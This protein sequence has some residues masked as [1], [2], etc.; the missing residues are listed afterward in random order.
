[1][2]R[3]RF[4]WIVCR[5]IF[6][7]R[8]IA[9]DISIL[10]MR[11]SVFDVDVTRMFSWRYCGLMDL[12]RVDLMVRQ[13]FFMKVLRQ[14][15]A[16]LVASQFITY[17]KSLRLFQK[18]EIHSRFAAWDDQWAYL[19]HRFVVN[20][21][22]IACGYVKGLFRSARRKLPIPEM[23]ALGGDYTSSPPFP[24]WTKYLDELHLS[25]IT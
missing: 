8:R 4:L 10:K 14:G 25:S 24:N 16:P 17:K 5:G 2:H 7:Q 19:E 22:T 21:E 13:G 23:F 3:L 18:Y 20:G 12:A 1:M 9:I 6:G 11:V 15:Y